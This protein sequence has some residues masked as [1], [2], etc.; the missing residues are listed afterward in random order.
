MK[1]VN[2]E[3]CNR[4][5]I[6][7]RGYISTSVS[8]DLFDIANVRLKVPYMVNNKECKL[9]F[10]GFAKARK[11]IDALFSQ[12]CDWFMIIRNYEKGIDG[13]FA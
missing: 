13:L 11:R 10:S 4:T 5:F 12:L 6:R 2:V 3:Y 9:V 1:D 8:L 7:E